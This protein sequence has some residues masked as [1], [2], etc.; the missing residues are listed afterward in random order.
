MENLAKK[1]QKKLPT[2][3][4]LLPKELEPISPESD[5]L[6]GK[7]E[8][9][10]EEGEVGFG[11]EKE[12]E[13]SSPPFEP[14]EGT[15]P[16]VEE[17]SMDSHLSGISELTSHDSQHSHPVFATMAPA[18]ITPVKPPLD[19]S[20]NDSQ[21]SKVSSGSR[22]SIVSLGEQDFK[23][24]YDVE[25]NDESQG[26]KSLIHIPLPERNIEE[27]KEDIVTVKEN[28]IH[29]ISGGFSEESNTSSNRLQIYT[30]ENSE[31][32][33]LDVKEIEKDMQGKTL[34]E[35]MENSTFI[36]FDQMSSEIKT[37]NRFDE[38]QENS[39]NREPS[40]SEDV[41]VNSDITEEK[42]DIKTED[43]FDA[44]QQN[45][46]LES[47]ED[48][49][50]KKSEELGIKHEQEVDLLYEMDVNEKIDNSWD[51]KISTK[52][53]EL[54]ER[55]LDYKSE[56]CDKTLD[57]KPERI[58]I[59]KFERRQ[60]EKLERK[61][62][63]KYE[64]K[65]DEKYEKNPDEKYEKKAEEKYEKKADEKYEKKPDEKYEKKPDEKY[66]KKPDEKSEKY[67]KKPDEKSEKKSE[68]KCEKQLEEKADRRTSDRSEKKVD[69]KST[70]KLDDKSTKKVEEKKSSDKKS[71]DKSERK[72]DERKSSEK[73][74]DDKG[75][76]KGE[77]KA[78]KK[79]DSKTDKKSEDKKHDKC[80]EERDKSKDKKDEKKR[81][82]SES[83]DSK[84]NE[85]IHSSENDK[86]KSDKHKRDH[87]DSR[88]RSEKSNKHDSK[89]TK[90]KSKRDE[91]AEKEALKEK[92][93]HETKDIKEEKKTEEKDKKNDKES[94]REKVK[95]EETEVSKHDKEVKKSKSDDKKDRDGK[96]KQKSDDKGKTRH[97]EKHRERLKSEGKE[98]S[99]KEKTRH[100]DKNKDSSRSSSKDNKDR[101]KQDGRD[102]SKEPSSKSDEKK[103]KDKA[104]HDEKSNKT[105]EKSSVKKSENKSRNSDHKSRDSGKKSKESKGKS[106]T[107]D[108]RIH[109]DKHSEDRRSADRDSNGTPHDRTIG[110]TASHKNGS[111]SQP[112]QSRR[113][114]GG[115]TSTSSKSD[116][117]G[118]SD[119]CSHSQ[120]VESP[121][122]DESY[123]PSKSSSPPSSLPFKKRPLSIQSD[124]EFSDNERSRK[125]S[126][127]LY[128][129][130]KK[131]KIAANIF[132]VKKIMML[133][134]SL[135]KK[136]RKK[137]KELRDTREVKQGDMNV[138][139]EKKVPKPVVI[140]R[141]KL[142]DVEKSLRKEVHTSLSQKQVPLSDVENDDQELKY[143][144]SEGISHADSEFLAYVKRL[145]DNDNLSEFS[146][147]DSELSET[148][149][150]IHLNNI[151][152][153]EI[154]AKELGARF[155]NTS[156]GI[157]VVFDE[158]PNRE[159]LKNRRI[160]VESVQ[161]SM[162]D[163]NIIGDTVVRI[164]VNTRSNSAMSNSSEKSTDDYPSVRNAKRRRH[165]SSSVTSTTSNK[166]IPDKTGSPS[167]GKHSDSSQKSRKRIFSRKRPKKDLSS[168]QEIQPVQKRELRRARRPNTRYS[169][170]DF[171]S[172]T[173]EDLSHDG[174]PSEEAKVNNT[175]ESCNVQLMSDAV[176]I[177]ND[178]KSAEKELPRN[179]SH[180]NEDSSDE[181]VILGCVDIRENN[182]V[183]KGSSEDER[184]CG[185]SSM[186]NQDLILP[187]LRDLMVE[188]G[189]RREDDKSDI[190]LI[191]VGNCVVSDTHKD[192]DNGES[193]ASSDA[194]R[195][196]DNVNSKRTGLG[197]SRRVGLSRP[198]PKVVSEQGTNEVGV[199]R[200]ATPPDFVMPLSPESDVSAS[201][202]EAKKALHVQ[203]NIF[204]FTSVLRK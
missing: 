86:R 109:R 123:S 75:D 34:N 46:S 160:S 57:D 78:D 142:G 156:N 159:V 136:E 49:I 105:T 58:S 154:V 198:R 29:D 6:K 129:K 161:E 45:K 83:K 103:T 92:S 146:N 74:S 62:D 137:Q 131:P 114:K 17:S 153:D 125:S 127:A 113:E 47:G 81:T 172:Y 41:P 119:S 133:R 167:D 143:F 151:N 56:G 168:P 43:K 2:L 63:E 180:E 44:F 124:E 66:E 4:D 202:G 140:K 192:N 3:T 158:S 93:K 166:S 95:K 1:E 14:I 33:S 149:D 177:L 24:R 89:E 94:G 52:S 42:D 138:K 195:S 173:D 61:V 111:D 69:E 199:N 174:F 189:F 204:S 87:G 48:S 32:N 201:S 186:L 117:G 77:D 37:E 16:Q 110:N 187:T 100:D 96:D 91:K 82:T 73:K 194:Y 185:D 35:N 40:Y 11:D 60:D 13:D 10:L 31:N 5:T 50:D 70:K 184:G 15:N 147:S 30:Q 107:D 148:D 152:F 12:E 162:M 54:L 21:L 157:E 25:S 144:E 155:V 38:K 84:K 98:K 178:I 141:T 170:K 164:N 97:D 26:S 175:E 128:S 203:G 112:S 122:K 139:N 121:R 200:T 145:L 101:N 135:A 165:R 163:F 39:S 179:I 51:E 71:D 53:E 59:E 55:K 76:K 115:S 197:R 171:A 126:K 193:Q 8:H 9:S 20:N 150:V 191:G 68:K 28:Y 108:H 67:E 118:N 88:S 79:Y 120:E 23:L 7:E 85:I 190:P 18:N 64:K 72:L 116:N 36:E 90:D 65:A 27:T 22:L 102:R 182:N 183:D 80:R 169:N 130:I 19:L 104:K 99:D 181:E 134:K 106:V 176:I 196:S 188:S 132:E